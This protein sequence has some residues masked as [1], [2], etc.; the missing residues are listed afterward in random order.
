[1]LPG[2]IYVVLSIFDV[3]S[4]C[5]RNNMIKIRVSNKSIHSEDSKYWGNF[6]PGFLGYGFSYQDTQHTAGYVENQHSIE[7]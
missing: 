3:L 4:N 7:R 1:M 6:I 5:R 2:Q